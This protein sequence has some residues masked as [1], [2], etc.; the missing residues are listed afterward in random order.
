MQGGSMAAAINFINVSQAQLTFPNCLKIVVTDFLAIMRKFSVTFLFCKGAN[1]FELRA[2]CPLWHLPSSV[3]LQTSPK[4]QTH[5][6]MMFYRL[7]CP[8][9]FVLASKKD[10]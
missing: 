1:F 6:I 8:S 5:P 2:E 4:N 3:V 10:K 9:S 7:R